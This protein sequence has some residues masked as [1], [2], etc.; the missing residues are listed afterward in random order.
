MENVKPAQSFRD[1]IVWQKAHLFVL[2]VYGFTAGFPRQ[3]IYGLTSQ[4]RR[5]AVSIPANIAEGFRRRGKAD[6]ARFM[7]IAEGSLE[8]C[9]YYLI[10]SGDL[11][12]GEVSLLAQA[13]EET[14]RLLQ[15]YNRRLSGRIPD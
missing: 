1:L 3:E 8:E 9:R 14:S 5:A 6:K 13:L 10:L 11:G 4:M 12:Y 2:A 15:A 7:N